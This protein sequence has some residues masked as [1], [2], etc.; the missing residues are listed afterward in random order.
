[1]PSDAEQPISSQYGTSARDLGVVATA[2]ETTALL[3]DPTWSLVPTATK[4]LGHDSESRRGALRCGMRS[5][6]RMTSLTTATACTRP[7]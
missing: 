3:A 6:W 5:A 2:A 7:S 1:M 4:R